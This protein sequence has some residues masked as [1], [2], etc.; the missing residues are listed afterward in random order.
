MSDDVEKAVAEELAGWMRAES[1]ER[2]V[3]E[4]NALAL[5]CDTRARCWR[6]G[7][8]GDGRE[9]I[10]P[11][12]LCFAVLSM[13]K[14]RVLPDRGRWTWGRL[15]M[16][17][18]DWVL[19]SEFDWMREPHFDPPFEYIP[20]DCAVEV[21][22]YPRSAEWIPEWLAD[23]IARQEKHLAALARRRERDRARR[24]AKRAEKAAKEAQQADRAQQAEPPADQAGDA[25]AG[26]TPPAP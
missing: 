4:V 10:A 18:S 1:F 23:G 3:L 11:S 12:D 19:H 9:E 2:V 21:D 5:M 26:Q 8:D 20:A 22:L 6:A 15:W 13:H 17:A 25:T 14:T 24:A 7:E 16:D